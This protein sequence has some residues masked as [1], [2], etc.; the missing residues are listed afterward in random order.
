VSGPAGAADRVVLGAGITAA[1]IAAAV[2]LGPL[3]GLPHVTD[4]VAYTLQARLFA[5]L[6]RTGPPTDQPSMLSYP[7]WSAEGPAHSPFPPGWPALLAL[8]EGLGLG[9]AVNPLLVGLVPLIVARLAALSGA[10][11]RA[12]AWAAALSPGLW[13]LGASRMAH[14]SVLVALG[15]LAVLVLS[16]PLR[17][18]RAGALAGL[19]AAYV[20]LAR[21][22]DALLVAGPLLAWG[23]LRAEGAAARA[24]LVGLPAV[25]AGLLLLDNALLTGDLLTFPM[26]AW[27]DAWTDPPRPGCD[28]LGFGPDVGCA[29]IGGAYGHS[30]ARAAD[31]AWAALLRLDR[32]L[33]GVPGGLLVALVGLGRLRLWPALGLGGALICGHALYWSPGLAYGARFY[34]PLYL[35]LPLGLAAALAPLGRWAPLAL[36]AAML[37]GGSGVAAA[38]ADR[39]WCVDGGLRARLEAHGVHDGVVFVAARGQRAAAWPALGVDAFTCDPMLEFGDAMALMDPRLPPDQGLQ[40]R[41]ALPDAASTAL[42]LE[43]HQPGRP[44]WLAVHDVKA[45]AWEIVAL[46]AGAAPP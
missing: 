31:A 21:P 35:V 26:R 39:L 23:L 45:D 17:T 24:A 14:T 6:S 16:G 41:H 33:I 36:G 37:A 19:A 12:S 13:A 9:W 4:E 2:A 28:R 3:E 34:H 1:L 32:L 20:V 5:G 15:A 44:A 18:A 8:G 42:Y 10:P 43:R 7:F 30:P 11:A 38:L 22:F 46:T 29:P 25:G 40:L 27:H